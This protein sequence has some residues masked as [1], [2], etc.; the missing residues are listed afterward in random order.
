MYIL[1]FAISCAAAMSFLFPA[2]HTSQETRVDGLRL[3]WSQ[4]GEGPRTLMLI[5][6]WTCDETSW[7]EQIEQLS[8]AYRVVTLDL[9][10][11][12]RSEHPG[13]DRFS[14]ELFVRAIEA[15]RAEAKAE[16]VALV[17]HSLGT[18]MALRYTRTYP[19]RV[20]GLVFVEGVLRQPKL[21]ALAARQLRRPN[22]RQV[23]ETTIRRTLFSATTP[24]AV[25]EHVLSM[26][27]GTPAATVIGVVDT[28]LEPDSWNGD[29]L[30][31]PLL[32]VYQ[33][34]SIFAEY[35]E[36]KR[37]FSALDYVELADT[38]H[39]L[40]ME[41]PREFNRLLDTF[42]RKQIF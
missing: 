8:Q 40:M 21:L 17:G 19:E 22:G 23:F 31:V 6:G 41:K 2:G 12:G 34:R 24:E 25:R 26:M 14:V 37:R 42:L 29:S 28:M 16:R 20:V 30:D 7:I 27:L 38:G 36:L 11:H 18:Q 39:F 5:H 4:S 10:G 9:P 3:H 33:R 15:V 35:E 32:G 13:D 1:H